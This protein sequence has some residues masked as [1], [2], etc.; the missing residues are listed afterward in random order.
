MS[1]LPVCLL[2][3]EYAQWRYHSRFLLYVSSILI[4]AMN[5]S[6]MKKIR[7][8]SLFQQY[9]FSLCC[10]SLPSSLE[11]PINQ[12]MMNMVVLPVTVSLFTVCAFIG[13]SYCSLHTSVLISMHLLSPRPFWK[14]SCPG[15]WPN[16]QSRGGAFPN[17]FKVLLL[18]NYHVLLVSTKKCNICFW[19]HL[20]LSRPNNKKV[21]R[22]YPA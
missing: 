21:S 17:L 16:E 3:A 15:C 6:L 1:K 5:I 4:S 13:K 7:Q 10:Q 19:D 12:I 9:H 2:S 18:V 11:N 20:L 8:A 14:R 22:C